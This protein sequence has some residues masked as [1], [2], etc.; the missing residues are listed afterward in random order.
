[1]AAPSLP[2]ALSLLLVI[3]SNAEVEQVNVRRHAS[4]YT[5]THIYTHCYN[6]KYP[7]LFKCNLNYVYIRF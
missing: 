3:D 7:I 4:P 2:L 5:L 6:R 1:M